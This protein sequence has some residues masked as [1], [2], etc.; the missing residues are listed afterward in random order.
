MGFLPL[1]SSSAPLASG[2][3]ETRPYTTTPVNG[4]TKGLQMRHAWFRVTGW[5]FIG[6]ATPAGI[7]IAI[8][9]HSLTLG[10]IMAVVS[11][12]MGLLRLYVTE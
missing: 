5:A 6:A 8:Q 4:N 3:G 11:A 1:P 9:S 2:V 10:C 7:A 12:G